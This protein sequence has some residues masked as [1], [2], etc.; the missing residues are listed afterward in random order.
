MEEA[1]LDYFQPVV[2][3]MKITVGCNGADELAC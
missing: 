3:K 2:V 1:N